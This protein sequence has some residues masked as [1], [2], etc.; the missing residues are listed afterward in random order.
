VDTNWVKVDTNW[1]KVDTNW[2]KVDTDW[3]KW[4]LNL[5][6]LQQSPLVHTVNLISFVVLS[7]CILKM[8]RGQCYP[9]IFLLR[10]PG[11]KQCLATCL[12]SVLSC[13]FEDTDSFSAC[14]AALFLGEVLPNYCCLG[15]LAITTGLDLLPLVLYLF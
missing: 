12:S 7:G 1:V 11:S 9:A 15:S 6:C 4:N 3:V 14:L 13:V 8:W 5:P 2:V 10:H